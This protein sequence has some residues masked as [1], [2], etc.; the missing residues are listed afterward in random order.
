MIAYHLRSVNGIGFR[1][2]C[3]AEPSG[4][5]TPQ[6]KLV[7]KQLS[8]RKDGVQKKTSFDKLFSIS[9]IYASGLSNTPLKLG[10][11]MA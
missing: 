11:G 8:K 9:H 6:L 7:Q 5:C 2:F 4:I 10:L 3:I 1:L